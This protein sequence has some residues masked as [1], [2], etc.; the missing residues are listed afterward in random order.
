MLPTSF[1]AFTSRLDITP[2]KEN[3]HGVK[4]NGTWNGLIGAIMRGVHQLI[5]L[6]R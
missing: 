5:N 2:V 1:L 4:I 3:T 6:S